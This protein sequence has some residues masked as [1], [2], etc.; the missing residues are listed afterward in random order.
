MVAFAKETRGILDPIKVGP[1]EFGDKRLNDQQRRVVDHVLSSPDQ[2]TMF[3]GSPGVGKT[4]LMQ[5]AVSAINASGYRVVTLAPTAE[6][7]RVTLRE[8]GFP[9]ANTVES[10]LQ[11][12]ALQKEARGQVIWVDEASL[13][14]VPAMERL[15]AVAKAQGCRVVLAGDPDQH[16]AVERGDAMRILEEHAGLPVPRVTKILR[17]NDEIY[18]EA[19]KA[20]SKGD[21][22]MAFATLEKMNAF[23]EDPDLGKLHARIADDYLAFAKSGKAALIIAPQHQEGVAITEKLRERMRENGLLK[24]ADCTV[25]RLNNLALTDAERADPRHYREGQVVQFVQNAPG[26]KR[27]ERVSVTG[28][29]GDQISVQ[30]V[31][32]ETKLLPLARSKSFQLYFCDQVALAAGDKIRITNNS[33]AKTRQRLDSGTLHTVSRI[34]PNGEIELKNKAV[35]AAGFGHLTHG[36][37]TTS[38]GSQSKTVTCALLAQSSLS[39]GASSREQMNVSLSRGKD[40]IRIYTDNKAELIKRVSRSSARESALDFVGSGQTKKDPP[41]KRNVIMTNMSRWLKA[42][43]RG[44]E[45]AKLSE[46]SRETDLCKEARGVSKGQGRG[47]G[48]EISL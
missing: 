44:R 37:Y 48:L 26:F 45:R 14:S 15:F 20:M 22:K 7:S 23:V 9:T 40:G 10:F 25:P 12:E 3:R 39:F 13:L 19:V 34:L 16:N 41:E 4:T 17:Q 43:Q 29:E 18:R 5:E 35:L 2:V 38:H 30:N 42:W 27:G 31:R 36:Y 32:G 28:R 8:A 24:G 11:S 46:R 6:A 1:H 33:F 47:I 21:V